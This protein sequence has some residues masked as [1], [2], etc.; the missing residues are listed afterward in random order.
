MADVVDLPPIDVGGDPNV[1]HGPPGDPS[2]V[3]RNPAHRPDEGGSHDIPR[4]RKSVARPEL[5]FEGR[6]GAFVDVEIMVQGSF[7][8]SQWSGY[9]GRGNQAQETI[10]IL[11]KELIG[12]SNSY[13]VVHEYNEKTASLMFPTGAASGLRPEA[14][15]SSARS[16]T[17]RKT[18]KCRK[19]KPIRFQFNNIDE[20]MLKK[21]G[22]APLGEGGIELKNGPS[23][24]K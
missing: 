4:R 2:L 24:R 8:G 7:K 1:P 16:R 20:D 22:I 11:A 23:S 3:C 14:G 18:N 15:R 17:I 5:S 12:Q 9:Q 10:L 6:D 13:N 21:Y 19:N